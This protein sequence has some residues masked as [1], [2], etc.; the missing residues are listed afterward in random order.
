M[1]AE[2]AECRGNRKKKN[3]KVNGIPDNGFPQNSQN[4]AEIKT[5]RKLEG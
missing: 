5:R 4:L 1:P 3:W 2:F